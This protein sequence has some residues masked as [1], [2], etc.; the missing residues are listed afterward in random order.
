MGMGHS[1]GGLATLQSYAQSTNWK[2]LFIR[3]GIGG[4]SVKDAREG[5]DVTLECRFSPEI[6]NSKTTFYWL[7]T[8]KLNQDNAAIGPT[9]L[10]P[11][12]K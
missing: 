7:R 8:N 9:S 2:I 6:T 1:V 12:Y 10:D 11:G 5:E 4:Q 3:A